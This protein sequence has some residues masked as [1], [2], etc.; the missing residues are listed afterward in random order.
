MTAH[1]TLN[2]QE[3]KL[4][5][6]VQPDAPIGYGIV[7]PGPYV[8]NGIPV[9]AIRDLPSPSLQNTHRCAPRIEGAYRRSRITGGDVLISVKGT[10]GR[11]GIVA[12]GFSGNISRDVARLRLSDEHEPAFWFQLLQSPEA[13]QRLHQ[14]AVGSTRQ[15]LSIGTLKMLSFKFPSRP[16][17][18]RISTVLADAD[19][20]IDVLK[21][22]LS[23]RQGIKR[24]MIQMLLA[25]VP[26]A[27]EVPVGAV[28]ARSFSGPSPTCDERNVRGE[29]WGVLKTTCSTR[30]RGWDETRHKVLPTSFWHKTHIEVRAGDSIITKAGPRHRVG[31]PAFVSFVRPRLI[32]SGKMICL[33]PNEAE[34]VPGFLALALSD[35]RTQAYLDERTTGMAESQVNFE[36]RDLLEAPVWLPSIPDQQ[37]ILEPLRDMDSLI[38][39][40]RS[41]L[42]KSRHLKE[43]MMQELFAGRT[44]LPVA[45]G[46]A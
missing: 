30:E 9:V 43:G 17:Q 31:V 44:R 7:Q 20:L 6:V 40:L 45:E 10:T 3:A 35:R 1:D 23:K 16:D 37:R 42:K 39:T 34:V 12:A 38:E 22:V 41:R 28:L 18:E 26:I 13:Q 33:R 46:A 15:E 11:I 5:D 8:R 2:W 36:N 4:L 19:Q 21:R 14:A 32:P 25:N 24:G 29:E 27:R